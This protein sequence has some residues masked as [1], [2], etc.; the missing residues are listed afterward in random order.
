M[1]KFSYENPVFH[2]LSKV[3]DV[4]FVSVLWIIFSLP[5]VTAGAS[6][7]ALYYTV[8]HQIMRGRG[9]V[10]TSFWT[11]FKKG[12]GDSVICGLIVEL[13]MGFLAFDAILTGS[14]L[15]QNPR[16]VW[17][18]AMTVIFVVLFLFA[19]AWFILVFCYRGRFEDRWKTS[20]KNGG[21]LFLGR[22]PHALLLIAVFLVS[23]NWVRRQPIMLFVLP[24]LVM[25]G[26][27]FLMEKTFLAI[28]SPEDRE[29]ER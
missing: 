25:M 21:Q 9:Y 17:L 18:S 20:L 28:M 29:R 24:A 1:K 11:T 2:Y 8:H 7:S 13:V 23:F 3:T 27:D 5:V 6:T 14:L 26:I 16:M 12:F 22:F 10:W 15:K 19:I 4:L